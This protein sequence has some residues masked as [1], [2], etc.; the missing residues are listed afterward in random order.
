MT[1]MAAAG[2]PTHHHHTYITSIQHGN[3]M[4][5]RGVGSRH[6]ADRAP[7]MFSFLYITTT[8][9]AWNEPMNGQNEMEMGGA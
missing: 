9:L 3:M 4:K 8:Y 7:G 6:D 1:S 2:T 5:G